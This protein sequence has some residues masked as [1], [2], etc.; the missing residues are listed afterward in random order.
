[1]KRVI[2]TFC[3]A[4]ALGLAGFVP[5]E[6]VAD[7]RKDTGSFSLYYVAEIKAGSGTVTGKVQTTD[8]K[9]ETYRLTPSDARAANMQGTVAIEKPDGKSVVVNFVKIGQ[10]KDLPDGWMGKGNRMNPL[11]PYRMVAA[12]QTQH[13]FGSRVFIPDLVGYETP[14]GRTLD[15]Y[16]WV[17]DIGNG[18]KGRNR[19]D[20]FVGAQAAYLAIMKAPDGGGK[21]TAPIEVENLPGAPAGLDPKTEIGVRKILEGIGQEVGEGSNGL[22]EAITEFQRK[23]PQIPEVEH[24]GRV[25]AVTLWFLT[26]AAQAAG[27][28]KSYPPDS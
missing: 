6:C 22:A 25:G 4:S 3:S 23:H 18:I 14:E 17:G 1:M 21:W 13:P 16:F 24:G 8:G 10:W 19:F 2:L 5:T 28:G 7:P 26:E 20:V 11:E 27:S 9:W 15:G 12:D